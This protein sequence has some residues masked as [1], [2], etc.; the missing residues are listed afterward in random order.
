MHIQWYRPY[1]QKASNNIET[2]NEVTLV[3]LTYML[4]CFTDFV[5][6]AETRDKIGL[7]YCGAIIG[8]IFV[9]LL[10]MMRASCQKL[11]I[12]CLKRRYAKRVRME[13]AKKKC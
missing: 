10:I 3:V 13:A 7:Y 1:E 9:H 2:F 4:Y 12:Y 11:R 8:N 5:P 6:A